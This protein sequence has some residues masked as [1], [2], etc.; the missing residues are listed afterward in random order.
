MAVLWIVYMTYGAM[1]PE[2]GLMHSF[3]ALLAIILSAATLILV[4]IIG[5][6]IRLNRAL[7]AA[8]L[9][10][11]ALAFVTLA[12][13]VL[14]VVLSIVFSE[15]TDMVIDGGA[16]GTLTEPNNTLMI[17]GCLLTAFGAFHIVTPYFIDPVGKT[18]DP[19]GA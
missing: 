15:E 17:L 14:F 19:Q 18:Q 12:G 13:G 6:P 7:R 1:D 5:L 3:H 2:F 11:P 16:H 4:G 8:W 10:R 9:K